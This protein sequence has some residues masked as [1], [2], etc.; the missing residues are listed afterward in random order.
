MYVD[1]DERE[2]IEKER[3]TQSEDYKKMQKI[4]EVSTEALE[5]DNRIR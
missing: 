1:D 5:N 2:R 3:K 4:S